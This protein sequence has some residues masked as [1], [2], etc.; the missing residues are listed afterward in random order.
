[1][2]RDS[3]DGAGGEPCPGSPADSPRTTVLSLAENKRDHGAGHA[4]GRDI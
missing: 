3:A 4:G 1:V 2:Y